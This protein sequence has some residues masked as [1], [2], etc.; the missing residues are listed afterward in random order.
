M[1]I[2]KVAELQE[3]EKEAEK[4][5]KRMF[6]PAKLSRPALSSHNGGSMR[7]CI[8]AAL[9]K[10]LEGSEG[11]DMRVVVVCEALASGKSRDEI[12]EMFRGQAD[13]DEAITAKY[14]DYLTSRG[15]HPWKCET[16]QDRCSSFVDC[17]QCPHKPVEATVI[18]AR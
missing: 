9:T 4:V 13:F 18:Q 17:E 11:N 8:V 1:F 16:I 6:L 2:T 14:V 5:G 7:P 10:Q 15:Y 3:P 12:I